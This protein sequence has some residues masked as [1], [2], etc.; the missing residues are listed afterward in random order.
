MCSTLLP[1][2][3]VGIKS[4]IHSQ[5]RSTLVIYFFIH[6]NFTNLVSLDY[7]VQVSKNIKIISGLH[8]VEALQLIN[9]SKTKND[10]LG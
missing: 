8:V 1:K 4:N 9:E 10:V 2:Y 3:K 7:P 5:N 6:R